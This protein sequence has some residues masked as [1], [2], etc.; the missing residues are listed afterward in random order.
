MG[1]CI[2]VPAVSIEGVARHGRNRRR[3]F[4]AQLHRL[5]E[6][7]QRRLVGCRQGRQQFGPGGAELLEPLPATLSL[8]S[9]ARIT[10]SGT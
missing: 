4:R 5:A 2:P 7:D 3:Q 1:P 6:R 10:F 8:M 9:S